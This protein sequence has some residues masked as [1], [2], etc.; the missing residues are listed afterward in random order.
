MNSIIRLIPLVAAS[1]LHLVCLC[2]CAGKPDEGPVALFRRIHPSE[3]RL[4]TYVSP[5]RT[6]NLEAIYEIKSAVIMETL[7]AL[8]RKFG[9]VPE[10]IVYADKMENM[11]AD[12]LKNWKQMLADLRNARAKGATVCEFEWTDGRTLATGL[13]VLD[14]GNIVKRVELSRDVAHKRE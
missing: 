10:V 3:S 14:A 9:D 2:G 5:V 11:E 12:A 8:K 1:V 13:L 7:G 4:Y 6:E